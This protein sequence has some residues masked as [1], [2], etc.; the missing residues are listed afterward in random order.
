MKFFE[1]HPFILFALIFAGSWIF[2]A[3]VTS[4]QGGR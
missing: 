2:L 1:R 4:T 3:V